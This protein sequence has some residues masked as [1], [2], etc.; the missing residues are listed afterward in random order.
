MPSLN[1]FRIVWSISHSRSG[2]V[3]C[4]FPQ[5]FTMKLHTLFRLFDGFSEDQKQ[6]IMKENRNQSLHDVVVG[7]YMSGELSIGVDKSALLS[8]CP[9]IINN[10]LLKLFVLMVYVLSHPLMIICA[11]SYFIFSGSFLSI[12]YYIVGIFLLVALEGWLLK[13]VAIDSALKN[14]TYFVELYKRGA[15]KIKDVFD[16]YIQM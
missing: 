2:S 6:T 5:F 1:I 4:L 15:I 12:L 7:K 10:P 14:K 8:S 13:K 3:N 9:K 11:F 16:P